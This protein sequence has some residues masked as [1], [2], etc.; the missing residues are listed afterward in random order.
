M[1]VFQKSHGSHTTG[2]SIDSFCLTRNYISPRKN[3]L[4]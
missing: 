3:E 4:Y 2:G 1:S